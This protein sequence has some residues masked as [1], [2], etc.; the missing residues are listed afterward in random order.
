M[1]SL[2]RRKFSFMTSLFE[3]NCSIALLLQYRPITNFLWTLIMSLLYNDFSVCPVLKPPV[4]RPVLKPPVFWKPP[5]RAFMQKRNSSLAAASMY[6]SSS[7]T[8]SRVILL[9]WWCDL[10][11]LFLLCSF[12]WWW[13]R[14]ECPF[15]VPWGTP[16]VVPWGSPLWIP[17]FR[18]SWICRSLNDSQLS[19][20]MFSSSL[21]SHVVDVVDVVVAVVL[22]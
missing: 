4:F 18:A 8:S 14:W 20:R 13:W 3:F 22:L 9:W 15:D 12:L 1:R 21:S 2:F 10:F 19:L 16:F 17:W 6:F 11:L 7:M 5:A